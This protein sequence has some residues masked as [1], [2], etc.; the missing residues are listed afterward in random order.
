[1]RT[2]KET[3]SKGSFDSGCAWQRWFDLIGCKENFVSSG[4]SNSIYLL[5]PITSYVLAWN[6]S[7]FHDRFS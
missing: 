3:S 2:T 7:E 1:M 5:L 6:E 4:F